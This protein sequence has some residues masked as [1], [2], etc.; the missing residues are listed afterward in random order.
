ME[1]VDW[2][3]GA[4]GVSMLDHKGNTLFWQYILLALF[5]YFFLINVYF[6]VF[7][8]HFFPQWQ[9]YTRALFQY[10]IKT[11]CE[12]YSYDEYEIHINIWKLFKTKYTYYATKEKMA[13]E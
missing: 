12:I 3:D 4:G 2:T 7:N 5:V 8:C 1:D 9:I 11:I 10:N 6:I 13:K